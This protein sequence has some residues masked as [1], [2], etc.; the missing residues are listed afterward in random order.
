[1]ARSTWDPVASPSVQRVNTAP[2]ASVTPFR[3]VISPPPEITSKATRTLGI[4]APPASSTLTVG[5]SGR[6]DRAGAVWASPAT[7]ASRVGVSSTTSVADPE[8]CWWVARIAAVPC[9]VTVASPVEEMVAT[10]CRPDNHT[11]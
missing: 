1:M 2:D 11:T 10:S 6:C 4:G 9:P 7:F 5:F 8:T 3:G